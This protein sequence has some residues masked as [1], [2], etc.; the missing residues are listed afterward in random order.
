MTIRRMVA[1]LDTLYTDEAMQI[2]SAKDLTV[3]KTAY[4]LAMEVFAISKN[5]SAEERDSL[6]DQIRRSSRSICANLRA[7]VVETSI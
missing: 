3:Y 2:K 6:T 4:E 1:T 7:S 5:F